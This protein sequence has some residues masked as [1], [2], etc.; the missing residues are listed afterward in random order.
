MRIPVIS[1]AVA[2]TNGDLNISYPVNRDPVVVDSGISEGYLRA[3]L[4]ITLA[5]TGPG[6]DR[7][8]INWNGICYRV[9]GNKL[10][11]ISPNWV[12]TELGTVAGDEICGLDYSF[13]NL[14]IAGGGNLYY[15]S[16]TGGF[17]QV[18][19]PDLGPVYDAIF[20]D[21]YTMTTDGTSIVVT[22]LDNPE[23]VNP[24]KYG[25]SEDD[26]DP[27]VGMV[28]MHGEVYYLN[29]YTIQPA[30]NIGGLGF[31]FQTIKT[32]TIPFGCCGSRAK[33]KYLSTIA[34]AGGERNAAIGVYLMG[35]GDVDKISSRAV[36]DDLATLTED[37]QAN[38]WLE[39]RSERDEQRLMVHTQRRTWVFHA[40][41]TAK[42]SIK[43]WTSYS[44]S[45]TCEGVYEG[46]GLVYCYGKFI[47]G[48]SSGQFGYL[49]ETTSLHYGEQVAWR[50]DTKL[51]YNETRRGILTGLELVGTPGRGV[52]DGRVFFS[53]TKDGQFWSLERATPGG[54][55][56][57]TAKRPAWR[58]GI[59]FENYM[60][61]RFRG[62]DGSMTGI[63]ALE[64]GIEALGA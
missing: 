56:G 41:A 28:H 54:R 2:D 26:P 64:A 10:V 49:D 16:L 4:G 21:G 58:P 37:E 45:K 35:A 62:V 25:S 36:D 31:P 13:D 24:I 51:I 18:T 57:Q 46:R 3:P 1:G 19:D 38:I 53:Y 29:R 32:G 15:Y 59:R 34:F 60:G 7:G 50:F 22:D 11:S 39:Q 27:V 20:V 42:S 63:A 14:I 55:P 12:V 61:L 40:Q 44:T 9:M 5:G 33:C 47:V 17:R 48:S 8:G 52:G 23:S 30:Q 6:A 43:T